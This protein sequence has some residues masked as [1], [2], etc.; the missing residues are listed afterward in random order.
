MSLLNYITIFKD[1]DFALHCFHFIFWIL[2]LYLCVQYTEYRVYLFWLQGLRFSSI[3]P[4]PRYRASGSHCRGRTWATTS[5][6]SL[7]PTH[8]RVFLYVISLFILFLDHLL[9]R[10]HGGGGPGLAHEALCL[11]RVRQEPGRPAVHHAGGAALLPCL[12]RL[13]VRRVLWCLWWN[14]RRW[15]RY[16]E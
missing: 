5:P 11:L 13:H 12:L 2:K 8:L 4:W 15:P 9:W 16:T 6:I 10:V 14:H 7:K 3:T 1:E